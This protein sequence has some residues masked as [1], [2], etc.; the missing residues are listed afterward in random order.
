M[1]FAAFTD[2]TYNRS[3]PISMRPSPASRCDGRLVGHGFTE[4]AGNRAGLRYGLPECASSYTPG[5]ACEEAC[6]PALLP[7]YV[8]VTIEGAHCC[9]DGYWSQ[10]W[11]SGGPCPA[12]FCQYAE[13]MENREHTLTQYE[14][15]PCVWGVDYVLDLTALTEGLCVLRSNWSIVL[16]IVGG[17]GLNKKVQITGRGF[18]GDTGWVERESCMGWSG[19]LTNTQDECQYYETMIGGTASFIIPGAG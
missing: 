11:P 2:S 18:T 6:G 9:G 1:P 12:I 13:E 10:W 16:E 17:V 7:K 5:L 3:W 15:S 14:S 4:A 8:Y 19:V